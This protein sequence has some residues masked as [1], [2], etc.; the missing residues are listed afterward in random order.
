[1]SEMQRIIGLAFFFSIGVLLIILSCAIESNWWS[2]FVVL[3]Y[4]VAPI[5]NIICS[6]LSYN[7]GFDDSS[8]NE[9]GFFFTSIFIVT[10]FGIPAV[11][12]H[13]GVITHFSASL[14]IIGGLMVYGTIIG[15][16]YFFS[17]G[18]DYDYI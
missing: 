11:L 13:I 9:V 1:M 5:P 18:N 16:R 12:T 2:L 14:S 10:G 15:Y 6:N 3:T 8:S 7:D 17:R 4:A